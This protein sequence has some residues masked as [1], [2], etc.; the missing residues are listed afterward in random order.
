MRSWLFTY[1][2]RTINDVSHRKDI[3]VVATATTLLPSTGIRE[4]IYAKR[5]GCSYP[6]T[7]YKS[8]HFHPYAAL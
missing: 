7:P 2:P 4:P 1:I 8:S 6:K 5:Y 3:R